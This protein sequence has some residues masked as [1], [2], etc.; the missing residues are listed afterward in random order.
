MRIAGVVAVAVLSLV[1]LGGVGA[2]AQ[3]AKAGKGRGAGGAGAPG[4]AWSAARLGLPA[5]AT[6]VAGID[7]AA[8]RKTEVFA[9]L[10]PKLLELSEVAEVVAAMKTTC[11]LDLP[12]VVQSVVFSADDERDGALYVALAGV[13]KARLSSCLQQLAQK[14]DAAAKVTVKH[15]GNV[16]TVSDG[17][18]SRFFGWVG[19]DV[20]VMPVRS[21][22]KAALLKW[23]GGKGAFAKSKPGKSIA[24][25]NPSAALWVVGDKTQEIQP[26][27]T[28]KG[29]YATVALARGK[30]DADVHAVLADAAQAQALASGTQ[31]QLDE[32]RGAPILPPAIATVLKAITIAAAGDEV[33]IKASVADA[34]LASALGFAFTVMGGP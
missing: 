27:I 11:K 15:D 20:V 25:V 23:V 32:A 21:D 22:D 33:A 24:K 31:R 6:L 26:G 18:S 30:L 4:S 3:P 5:E 34:D 13:D 10:Y 28:M 17:E 14:L 9:V 7:V 19:K 8:L 12:A 1:S 29:G 16:T 2:H